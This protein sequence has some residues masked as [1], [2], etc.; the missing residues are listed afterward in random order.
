M[1]DEA[2]AESARQSTPEY[3]AAEARRQ[4]DLREAE[5][6][7]RD[8]SVDS[9]FQTVSQALSSPD[10]QEICN[11]RTKNGFERELR[12]PNN[13]KLH[14]IHEP[15]SGKLLSAEVTRTEQAEPTAGKPGR[16][17]RTGTVQHTA[18]IKLTSERV[19]LRVG[20]RTGLF[21]G[22]ID[23]VSKELR[24]P[25]PTV[26]C[27]TYTQFT[28][29]P[30]RYASDTYESTSV[31]QGSHRGVAGKYWGYEY[32]V[33]VKPE[34]EARRQNAFNGEQWILR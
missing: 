29:S 34:E 22:L 32:A 7:H 2:A 28:D 26:P 33:E 13:V 10:Q 15:N 20:A 14:T 9:I 24:L 31:A 8:Q 3:K 17:M 27:L 11:A 25:P 30:I 16:E 6:A 12:L 21:G 5:V 19:A 23:W 1:A 4:D 18:S